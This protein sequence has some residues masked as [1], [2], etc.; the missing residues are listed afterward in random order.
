MAIPATFSFFEQ[1]V[2]PQP[3]KGRLKKVHK[4]SN[5]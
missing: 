2:G 1:H 5:F 4:T 3:A